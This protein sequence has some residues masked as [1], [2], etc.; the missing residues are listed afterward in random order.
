M[1]GVRD[2]AESSRSAILS[3][4]FDRSGPEAYAAMI[5]IGT[6]G[7]AGIRPTRFRELAHS[8]A[9]RDAEIV[10]WTPR[11]VVA[12][13][14]T[15]MLPVKSAD[16]FYVVVLRTLDEIQYG[17]TQEDFSSRKLLQSAENEEQVQGWLAEQFKLRAHERYH[18][19]REPEVAEK[20]EP[21][22]IASAITIP[23]EVAIEVKDANKGW[24]ILEL[25]EALISQLAQQYLRPANRRHGVLVITLHTPRSWRDPGDNTRLSFAQ[26]IK[27]LAVLATTVTSNET[28]SISVRVIGIDVTE[29]ESPVA[30]H[31]SSV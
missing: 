25:E 20:K 11:E 31:R 27:R 23:V 22:I 21:D 8:K 2:S 3:A 18:V 5:E 17:L 24:T 9:E 14:A 1:P 6:S 4:I 10:P 29:K 16:G 12:F 28:G 26:V 19:H 7:I 30:N 15:Y 13:E